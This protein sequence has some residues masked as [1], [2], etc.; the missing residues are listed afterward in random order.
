MCYNL[1]ISSIIATPAHDEV[2]ELPQG[3][4]DR[5]NAGG[6]GASGSDDGGGGSYTLRGFAHTGKKWH[7]LSGWHRL[8]AAHDGPQSDC[9]CPRAAKVSCNLS[10]VY[11]RMF[12]GACPSPTLL[13]AYF[14]L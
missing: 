13:A 4:S 14:R 10:A 6:T 3:A 1:N 8:D 7:A 9:S 12:Q 11:R 2:L 5:G